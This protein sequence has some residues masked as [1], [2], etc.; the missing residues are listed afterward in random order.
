MPGPNQSMDEGDESGGAEFDDAEDDVVEKQVGHGDDDG[1]EEDMAVAKELSR[2]DLF[3][4][5]SVWKNREGMAR[6]VPSATKGS[7]TKA[8]EIPTW[9][10]D[11][12]MCLKSADLRAG[13]E[14]P[15]EK[16]FCECQKCD[17][18]MLRP[19]GGSTGNLRKHFGV[20]D[21]SKKGKGHDT[22][23]AANAN[24]QQLHSGKTYV[25]HMTESFMQEEQQGQRRIQESFG[26][27]TRQQNEF[28]ITEYFLLSKHK[29]PLSMVEDEAF[30]VFVK[31]LAGDKFVEDMSV[32]KLKANIM[33]VEAMVRLYRVISR[34][35]FLLSYSHLTSP[36][37]PSHPP[38]GGSSFCGDF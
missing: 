12:F 16:I 37:A 32:D 7:R 31:G 9:G 24:P 5:Y 29:P 6:Y 19:T 34:V 8:G 18:L 35:Q 33:K 14:N 38:T 1:D 20:C 3:N 23:A 21:S 17:V 30:R 28:R 25:E 10:P 2:R 27:A 11:S 15:L 13:D 4:Y 36:A 22:T 26:P